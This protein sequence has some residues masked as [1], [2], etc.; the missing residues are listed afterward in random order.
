ML[1]IDHL[2][3]QSRWVNVSPQAKG[4]GYLSSLGLIALMPPW[5]QVAMM[6]VLVALVC[7]GSRLS[8]RRYLLW[9]SMPAAFIAFSSLVMLISYHDTSS[10]LMFSIALGDGYLGL[11]TAM[12][13]EAVQTLLR[14]LCSVCATL[15]FITATPFNQCLRLLKAARLPNVL[16]EQL[17]L[18]YRFIFIVIEEAHATYCAQTLRFGYRDGSRWLHSLAMLCGI[19][20]QRVLQRHNAMKD[21]L[22]VKLYQG[23]FP[24]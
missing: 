6:V 24:L 23:E 10:P 1:L 15:C 9:I 2:A 4:I 21:V 22:A 16:I 14:C 19:L 13:D 17:L 18:T 20:L 12:A 5:G 8:L 3:Y 11:S 7:I